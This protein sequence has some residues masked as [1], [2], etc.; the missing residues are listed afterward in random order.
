[1]QPGRVF[2][3][4]DPDKIEYWKQ[5]WQRNILNEARARYCDTQMGEEIGW[6]MSPVL[7]GFYYGYQFTR[8]PQWIDRLVDW[9]DSWIRR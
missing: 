5:H 6:L 2:T 4:A 1:M 7:N 8:D 9:T 3:A